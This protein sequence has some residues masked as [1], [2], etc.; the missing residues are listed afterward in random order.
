MYKA[1]KLYSKRGLIMD[2]MVITFANTSEKLKET[3]YFND[4][5]MQRKNDTKLY[6]IIHTVF[7]VAIV[8]KRIM[9]WGSS[10]F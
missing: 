4:G 2:D 7:W 10:I 5:R 6:S 3:I 8:I 9:Y 1:E